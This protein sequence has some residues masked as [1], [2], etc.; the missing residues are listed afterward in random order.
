MQVVWTAG[1]ILAGGPEQPGGSQPP[2][3]PGPVCGQIDDVCASAS[4]P[5][6]VSPPAAPRGRRRPPDDVGRQ[7]RGSVPVCAPA[8]AARRT[9]VLRCSS[10]WPVRAARPEEFEGLRR[11]EEASEALFL[12]HGI[13]PFAPSDDDHLARSA[14]VLVCDDDPPLGFAAVGDVDGAAHIWQ[15]SVHP[16]AGRRG[17]GTALVV[18]ACD[19]ARE[20]GYGAVT[21]TTFRDVPWN[22]PFYA[23]LGFSVVDRPTT[24][25][26]AIRRREQARGDD[27]LGPRVAM[28]RDL[29]P[30]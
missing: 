25:L 4:G 7:G 28:A 2:W 27:T 23:R 20:R 1:D 10:R 26:V 17:R 22:A 13:G 29:A 21:L 8:A 6:G 5:N 16:C 15:L 14:V 30:G 11:I 12:E 19:W 24:G 18:A 3:P 9:V